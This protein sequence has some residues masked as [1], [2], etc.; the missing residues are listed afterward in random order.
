[1]TAR[2][3]RSGG[4][5]GRGEKASA[6]VILLTLLLP[7]PVQA[8]TQA[9]GA[10][11]AAVQLSSSLPHSVYEQGLLRLTRAD[12]VT[13]VGG[14]ANMGVS[15]F[16]EVIAN[17]FWPSQ[18]RIVGLDI[19]WTYGANI[20]SPIPREKWVDDFLTAADQ[21]GISVAFYL[22]DWDANVTGQ[23]WWSEVEAKY[24]LMRTATPSGMSVNQTT[25]A[26]LVLN[27]PII[28]QQ[29]ERDLAQLLHYYGGHDSWVGLISGSLTVH[30]TTEEL[31]SSTGFDRYSLSAF[32]NST[33]YL[34]T[35]NATGYY[36]DGTESSLWSAF[37]QPISS[38]E[39]ASGA[40]QSP[41]SLLL[42]NGSQNELAVRISVPSN[43]TDPRVRLY[44]GKT[45]SPTSPIQFSLVSSSN[46]TG[47][48]SGE[49]L[50][51]AS[52]GSSQVPP[53]A[54]W[55]QP[56]QFNASLSAGTAYWIVA[57]T[58]SGNATN[59]Y[60]L[61]YRDFNVDDSAIA[62]EGYKGTWYPT[63][64]AVAWITDSSGNDVR[65]YPYQDVG[66]SRNDGGSV[67]QEFQTA[68]A[69]D[70]RTVY[71]LVADKLYSTVNSTLQ[72]VDSA[73]STVITSVTFSQSAF[74]G[75]YWWIPISLPSAVHLQANHSYSLR[76][77]PVPTGNGWQ[78]HYLITN[79]P[80]AGFQGMAR[81]QLFRLDSYSIL[82]LNLMH[83]GPPGRAGPENGFPGATNTTWYAQS[84]AISVTAP[85]LLVQANV[86]K[87]CQPGAV[88]GALRPCAA[89]QHPGDLV[90]Q[91]RGSST[92]GDFPGP[93]VLA[94]R[95][96]PESLIPWGRVWVN[97]TNWNLNLTAGNTYWVVLSTVN[98]TMGG[99]YPW[100]EESAYQHLILRSS[101][102]GATWGRPREPA[103]MLIDLRTGAQSFMVEPEIEITAKFGGAAWVS[104]SI[105]V[106][107][108]TN[109]STILIFVSREVADNKGT[110]TV[111]I[112][113][114]DGYGHPS[115]MVL[116]T[117]TVTP[118]E[119]TI[120]WK[121][122]FGVNLNYPITLQPGVRYWLVFRSVDTQSGRKQYPEMAVQAF[123]FHNDSAS[124]GGSSLGAYESANAGLSWS[125]IGGL[126]TDLIFGLAYSPLAA[127]KPTIEQLVG[128]VESRQ[129]LVVEGG[130]LTSAWQSFLASS[131]SK[132]ETDV[133]AWLNQQNVSEYASPGN[134]T[135]T[136]S[137]RT[138]V[139]FDTNTP[140]FFEDSAPK[141][142]GFDLYP[143]VSL[144]SQAQSVV[145]TGEIPQA[146][147]VIDLSSHGGLA[148]TTPSD[149][150]T[151]ASSLNRSVVFVS[152][153]PVE[154]FGRLSSFSD[155]FS[156]LSRMRSQGLSWPGLSSSS[157]GTTAGPW[158]T[159]YVQ[160][161]V[162]GSGGLSKL[163]SRSLAVLDV[164]S[165]QLTWKGI[166]ASYATNGSVSGV[167][168]LLRTQG[169]LDL[170]YSNVKAS[171]ETV[172][173][174]QALIVFTA[175]PGEEIWAVINSTRT[176]Q[177]V[178]IGNNSV[179]EAPDYDSLVSGSY[180]SQGWSQEPNGML[181]VRYPSSGEDTVRIVI[182]PPPPPNQLLVSLTLAA[183]FLMMASA[184]AADAVAWVLFLRKRAQV[185]TRGAVQEP[186]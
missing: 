142:T 118:S 97:A 81:V 114:D 64:S 98:G 12:L 27:S 92:T 75:T 154:F 104:Q 111:D 135:A 106:G 136:I 11:P 184:V 102:G 123:S 62:T 4:L 9:N 33:F 170:D 93:T 41:D 34:R 137:Q 79:P 82:S 70:V 54:N 42:Y 160:S 32:A 101:D 63:G 100:K 8:I 161:A 25:A 138:W 128:E 147:P 67:V 16:S 181:L 133:V 171:S 10:A 167:T 73:G 126:H 21:G 185:K 95:T 78:W 141:A 26:S 91:V 89:T 172:Y 134:Q 69:I 72:I 90:I 149:Y 113:A 58:A 19:G 108:P 165:M 28:E 37:R 105:E 158:L 76:L 53:R 131:T 164:G 65:I 145:P 46:V 18:T 159:P 119:E 109:V 175:P 162:N 103:D 35:V 29:L 40:W 87:Y 61:W 85:L 5:K 94:S 39:L 124:Y 157:A 13:L 3:R 6:V 163:R 52:L 122:I 169:D 130:Q 38:P 15:N 186:S 115:Q 179:L 23:S 148:G 60:Q 139:S 74:N 47:Y 44:I 7:L 2:L 59:A 150:F 156:L 182:S 125:L 116:A 43:I 143:T 57:K 49:S 24:P 152:V 117:G 178:E 86:E 22:P 68:Q 45:G 112:R 173:P 107:R 50:A 66:I 84:Y 120:T 1:M 168:Y 17:D 88:T 140:A 176:V 83:I 151:L 20:T 80:K 177:S 129:S 51:N 48:P 132:I 144:N 99:Y 14:E 110:I 30:S 153:D 77:L 31:L 121:G 36:P 155:A 180:S 174:N 71:I 183:P 127:S 55:T 56:I 96:I 146:I 166:G